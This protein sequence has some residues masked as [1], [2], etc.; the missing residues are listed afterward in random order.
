M[1]M[2][3]GGHSQG[4]EKQQTAYS[5]LHLFGHRIGGHCL[6]LI[7]RLDAFTRGTL[8]ILKDFSNLGT[9]TTSHWAL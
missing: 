6:E 9:A 7:Q 5:C 8:G 4:L 1:A 3:L 2:A